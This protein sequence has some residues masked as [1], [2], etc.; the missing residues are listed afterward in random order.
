M[1]L[2][3]FQ[4]LMSDAEKNNYAVGYFE[5]WSLD[6]FLAVCDAA[7]RKKSPVIIGFSGIDFPNYKHYL[8]DPFEI[9]TNLL[10]DLA[11]RLT[12]PVCTIFNE[13]P[14]KDLVLK[15]IKQKLSIIMFLDPKL[16]FLEQKSII[17]E[18]AK[19]AH[20]NNV[21]IEGEIET[22][23]GLGEN[24]INASNDELLTDIKT[25]KAFVEETGIDAL[26]VNI[27]QISLTSE[28]KVRLNLKHLERLKKEIN[29][30]LV[31][32]GGS[33]IYDDDIKAAISIGI[34][35]INIGKT[36]KEAYFKTLRESCLE[37]NDYNPYKVIGSGL[38]QDVLV[39]AK[40]SMQKAVEA[41][42][43]LF[44]STDKAF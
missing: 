29:A 44:N 39:K 35:K 18:L 5:C 41:C 17:Q 1:S 42:M 6:S 3:S 19:E 31:L 10:T 2:V 26:A 36:I 12:V 13:S 20:R 34:R 15:A 28:N 30:P 22:Q 9:Y 4:K 11:S 32:H 37:I 7:E 33:S 38:D 14:S 27:G 21:A 40:I 25:A 16:D 8:K 43:T 24:I 23:A